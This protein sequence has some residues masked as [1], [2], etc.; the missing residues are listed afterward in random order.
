M[1]KLAQKDIKT[2]KKEIYSTDYRKAGQNENMGGQAQQK[3][4]NYKKNKNKTT[5]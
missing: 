4:R 3:K 1:L 2:L 5:H